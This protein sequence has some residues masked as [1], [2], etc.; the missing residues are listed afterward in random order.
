MTS[1]RDIKRVLDHWF[2][3]RPTQVADRVLD[4]V[5]DRIARQP[6]QPAWRASWR[7]FHVQSNLKLVLGAAA[8]IVIAV[9]GF[10]VLQPR[11]GSNV[12]GAVLPG[13]SPSP[14]AS[15]SPS[16]A[17]S[18]S[19]GA[20]FPAWFP[21]SSEGAGILPAGSQTTRTFLAGSTFTV[22][23]G[24]VND[25]DNPFQYSLFPDS[26]ANETNYPDWQDTVQ[27][28]LLTSV[29]PNNMFAICDATGLFQGSTAAEIVDGI[30]ANEA[31]STSDPVDV[32]IGG[33]S[34]RQVD[35]QISPD[36]SGTCAPPQEP[37][38]HWMGQRLRIIV[39][40]RPVAGTIGI[41]IGSKYAA[42][43]EAFLAEA[44]PIIESWQF[45]L[46]PGAS[47]SP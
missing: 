23:E 32:T 45:E 13:P 5:A 38:R 9:A 3:E 33:L 20:A 4:E 30:V 28:M 18:P 26:P 7:D 11:S 47:P 17:P 8:V 40:D 19:A 22:P 21:G 41:G 12:G 46:G 10:A 35:V 14:V 43:F 39:L 37:Q 1:E 15:A 44:M 6:Q 25:A 31:L 34:G 27:N 2:T 24:W 16:T 36:W 42:D 29:V